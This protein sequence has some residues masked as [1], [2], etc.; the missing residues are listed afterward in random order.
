MPAPKKP[1]TTVA[2]YVRHSAECLKK[3]G[4]QDR[5]YRRCQCRKWIYINEAGKPRRMSAGT[6]SWE[7]AEEAAN[8]ERIRLD[9]VQI[10]LRRIAGTAEV[11][12]ETVESALK[13]WVNGFKHQTDSTSK[14]YKYFVLKVTAWAEREGIKHL[15]DVTADHL[16][17]WRGQWSRD[18]EVQGDQMGLTTQ[19]QLQGRLKV[20]FK[21][22]V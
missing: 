15:R 12:G 20:F 22:A 17:R 11:N 3:I 10:E 8:K 2:V 9:P 1:I 21:W 6:R 4:R 19:S 13:Q 18:S 14:S 16:D 5:N 7:Q